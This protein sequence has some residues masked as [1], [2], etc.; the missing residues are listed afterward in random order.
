MRIL[1]AHNFYQLP[2]GE[3]R[4]FA[5]EKELL[6]RNGHEV[7]EYVRRNSEISDGGLVGHAMLP[8]R[9]LWNWETYADLHKIICEFR[10]HIAH[11]HNTL[12]LISPSAYSACWRAGIPIVQSLHNWR[13]I[14][15][16]GSLIYQNHHCEECVGKII[17]L[18]GI[19]RGCYRGSCLQ[20]AMI[21]L[22][23]A[24]HHTWARKIARY[25]AFTSEFKNKLV[26]AGYPASR[27][28]IKPHFV[29]DPGLGS[30]CGGYT[31]YA[32]RFS[33]EKGLPTLLKAWKMLPGRNL[34]LCGAGPLENEVRQFAQANPQTVSLYPHLPYD[35]LE[36]ILKKAQFLVWPSEWLET[37]GLIAL[38][39]MASGVPVISSDMKSAA[40]LVVDGQTGLNFL[41]GDAADLA[42]KIRWAYEHPAEM[43]AMGQ[44]A[45]QKYLDNYTPEKNYVQLLNIYQEAIRQLE[46][47]KRSK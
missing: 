7:V 1:V 3:D 30:R 23:T 29:D 25:I 43:D 14:C 33:S 40:H 21:G 20:T 6:V 38:E 32:G 11:F 22:I 47:S 17:P 5:S 45:R 36:Y 15:P 46:E 8:A 44:R 35:E 13:L 26:D 41:C 16:V 24:A 12:P 31:L 34:V 18:P 39:A 9:S 28:A 37:F 4:V 27:I 19:L 10:P 2:G 42:I